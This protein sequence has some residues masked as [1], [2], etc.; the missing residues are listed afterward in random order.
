MVMLMFVVSW[1]IGH[2]LGILV[3]VMVRVGVMP[4]NIKF[5]TVRTPDLIMMQHRI[6]TRCILNAKTDEC[7]TRLVRL[8]ERSVQEDMKRIQNPRLDP[9]YKEPTFKEMF[10]FLFKS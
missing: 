10:S 9:S 6:A 8:V 7:K 5:N 4:A 2:L 3:F 1:R